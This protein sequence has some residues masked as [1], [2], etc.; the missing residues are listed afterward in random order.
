MLNNDDNKANLVTFSISRPEFLTKGQI[1]PRRKNAGVKVFA[2]PG[3]NVEIA[4]HAHEAK[5]RWFELIGTTE[6]SKRFLNLL[7]IAPGC[8]APGFIRRRGCGGRSRG[9]LAAWPITVVSAQG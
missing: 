6:A 7:R 3:R 4:F 1:V 9:G 8:R 2:D 5:W